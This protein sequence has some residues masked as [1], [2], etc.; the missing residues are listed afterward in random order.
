VAVSPDGKHVVSGGQDQS[1]RLWDCATG[2][3]LRTQE[4][5]HVGSV[6]CVAFTPDG[7]RILSG[8]DDAVVKIWH[9]SLLCELF[10]LHGHE[11]AIRSIACTPDGARIASADEIA[12]KIWEAPD[13]GKGS[14][15]A[16]GAAS[17]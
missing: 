13:H 1:I 9:S 8:G 6:N 5:A 2:R 3:L 14:A 11:E 7:S 16:N 12:V 17:D 15:T 4:D 10:S